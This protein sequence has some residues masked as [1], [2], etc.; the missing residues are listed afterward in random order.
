MDITK[1]SI[2][3]HALSL[4]SK[5]YS[6]KEL[7]KAYIESIRQKDERLGAFLYVDEEAALLMAEDADR[8]LSKGDSSPLCGIP[9]ALKDNICTRSLPTTCASRMLEGYFPPYNATAWERLSLAGCVL[10]GKTNMDEFA[11][12]SDT[13]NSAFK[14]TLNPLDEKRSPGGSSGGSA[15]AVCAGEAAFALGSDTGGSVR[16]PSAFC[17]LV[18]MK[19]TYGRV[20]RYGL[21]AFASSLDQIGPITKTVWDNGAV[22]SAISGAD[23]H[24]LTCCEN[25]FIPDFEGFSCKGLKVGICTRLFSERVNEATKCASLA[26]A[27]LLRSLGAEIVYTDIPSAPYAT[28]AYYIISSAESSS[29]LARY[30]GLRYGKRT[31][32]EYS[33][34]GELYS[35]SRGEGFGQ[36]VKRRIL[37]GTFALC[38]GSYDDYYKKACAVRSLL[39]EDFGRAF[40]DCHIIIS[41]TAP[42]TA[43]ILSNEESPV[44]TYLRDELGVL[45]NMAGLPALTLPFSR[46]EKGLPIG[47]QLMG[48]AFSENLLYGVASILEKCAHK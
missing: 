18:G 17:G 19:P 6:S 13:K 34:I 26:A 20:S 29:N 25:P 45:A 39:K 10:L 35:L 37:L 38:E 41:P 7:T 47:V 14:K 48:R 46:D 16:T 21:I 30:D 15:A 2:R 5:E 8:R 24:D 4:K 43:P 44:E 9:M 33:S 11:M 3:E 1:K 28:H 42:D 23:P 40:N 27:E 36:E 31:E 22:L 12:G 32:K